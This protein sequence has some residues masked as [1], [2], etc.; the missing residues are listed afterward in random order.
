VMEKTRS[1]LTLAIRQKALEMRIADT[2]TKQ[3][4]SRKERKNE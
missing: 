2:N 1:D 3:S 4:K